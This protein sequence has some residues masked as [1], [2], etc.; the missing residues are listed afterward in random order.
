MS[1]VKNKNKKSVI[2]SLKEFEEKYFPKSY[3]KK[4][5]QRPTDAY[6]LGICLANESLDKLKSHLGD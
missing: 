5:L 3:A 6:D 1:E 2:R 4:S